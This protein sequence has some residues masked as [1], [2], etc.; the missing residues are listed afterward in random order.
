M[1][2]ELE[3]RVDEIVAPLAG[4]RGAQRKAGPNRVR[5]HTII[6]VIL[7]CCLLMLLALA[8]TWAALDLSASPEPTP[9][10]PGGQLGCLELVAG[11]AGHAEQVLGQRGYEIHWKLIS[12]EAPSGK[13]FATTDPSSVPSSAI[14]ED[15]EA[16]DEA[17]VVVFVHLATDPY[18]PPTAPLGCP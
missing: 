6:A 18:A 2:D 11:S 13:T 10:S 1:S 3:R 7:A 17:S 9:V 4:L 14:V 12:Y 8:A 15:I 16:N 5:R